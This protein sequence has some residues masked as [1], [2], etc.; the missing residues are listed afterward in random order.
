MLE[1]VLRILP[2]TIRQLLKNL[3]PALQN[4]I[5]EIRVRVSRPL[6][7]MVAGKPYYPSGAAGVYQV[8]GDDAAFLLSQ[9]S[10]YSIYAFEEELRRGFI[11]IKGGHRV[12]LA[13]KVVLDKGQVKTLRDI[14]S[15]NIR[16]ARETIGAANRLVS[17][18]YQGRWLNTLIIG[19]PQSGKTTLLRD[20]ARLISEGVPE[21]QIPS[22]KVGIVDE[23]SEI[24]A[25]MKGVPQLQLGG[26]VDV[27]DG[28]PKAEGMMMMI[29]SMSPDVL[30][31]D[32]I[33]RK[34]DVIAVQEALHAGVN[35]MTTAHGFSV[36]DVKRRPALQELIAQ[37]AFERQIELTRRTKPGIVK[38]IHQQKRNDVIIR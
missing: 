15:F 36:E 20:L 13:G 28:C 19:P 37:G 31:V 8:K 30:I 12:G 27:L 22:L 1:D 3:E 7:V 33:G 23:R 11:T 5:E 18:L 4:K 14:S 38:R 17:E 35:V 29:R 9:L 10:Q 25:S 34:E 24:A 6:E 21:R 32:E 2:E 26:R 16:I